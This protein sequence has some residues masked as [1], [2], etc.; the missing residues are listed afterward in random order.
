MTRRDFLYLTGAG[1]ATAIARP[2]AEAR[3][4]NATVQHGRY[5]DIPSFVVETDLL[6]AEFVAIGGRMV[7]LLDKRLNHEF[8]FQR[9]ET[10]YQRG[11]YDVPLT[12]PQSA[13]YDDM[14]PTIA[15]CYN[16]EFPWNGI[17]M[18]DHGETW[19]LDWAVEKHSDALVFSV[20]GVRLPYRLI[21]EVTVPAANRLRMAY[22]LENL[23]PYSMPYLW[24]AHPMLGLEERAR[25]LLPEECRIANVGNSLSGRLGKYGDQ[26]TWPN[27]TDSGGKRHDLSLIRSAHSNDTEAYYFT[28]PLASGWCGL[29]YP[30][31]NR[32][33][34]IFFPVDTVPFMGVVLAE[35]VRNDGR[36]FAILEP[37]SVPYG[38][39]DT[40]KLYTKKS[41]VPA[42]ET[43]EWYIEFQIEG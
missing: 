21:R 22:R 20:H 3:P 10:D 41:N 29:M 23:S 33:L 39:L 36:F 11:A 24:A 31:I 12:I 8:L 43:R 9:S 2:A 13:G 26:I 30:S 18:P 4:G 27:W 25:I 16:N 5:K 42:R 19:T 14:F 6:R 28:T 35:G 34:R 40:A 37:C 17:R 38:R 15:E 7:S 32:T 1:A